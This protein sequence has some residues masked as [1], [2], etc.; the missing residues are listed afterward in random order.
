MR[1]NIS[2]ILGLLL[3][4]MAPAHAEEAKDFSVTIDGTEFPI[5]AGETIAA[6]TKAGASVQLSLKRSEFMTFKAGAVSFEHRSD[7]SVA[8]TDIDK[9]VH[10]HMV[11]SALGTIAI[12]QQYDTIDPSTLTQLM[13]QQMSK[14]DVQAGAK[15]ESKETVRALQDG[16][17]LKGL[18]ATVKGNHIDIE[19]EALAMPLADGGIMAVTRLDK[20]NT[21]D[22]PI[23]DR[24]W[25]SLKAQ[26]P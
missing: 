16:R 19:I 15:I 7:L 22:Q 13:V 25:T 21:A 18:F 2:A 10:Q 26:S 14:D 23:L 5:N 6:R 8:S 17:T 11:A 24:F 1:R 12:L 9:D 3:V 4:A 20:D